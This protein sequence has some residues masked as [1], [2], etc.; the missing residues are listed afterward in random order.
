MQLVWEYIYMMIND[1]DGEE[2]R[3][4]MLSYY[5]FAEQIRNVNEKVEE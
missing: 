3:W 1:Y 5:N 4:K 2:I